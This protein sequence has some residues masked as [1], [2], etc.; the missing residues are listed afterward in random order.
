MNSRLRFKIIGVLTLFVLGAAL[1]GCKVAPNTQVG[2]S[3]PQL[4][5]P[6]TLSDPTWI[7]LDQAIHQDIGGREDVLAYLIYNISID[8]VQ[9]SDD[10]SLAL[11]WISLVDKTTG[12]VQSGEPGLVIGHKAA[13]G[14]WSVVLQADP[15]FAA[16]LQAVPESLLSAEL[17]TE[18]MPA[19]QQSSKDGT[20]YTGY[21]LPW[22][23][24]QAKY[25]TGSIGHVFTYKSCP[26][27]CLYA[28]DFADGTQFPIAAAK[29]GVVKYAVWQYE[30][31]N[32][33]NAN[34]LVIED[35]TTTPTTYMVY[36]HLA[37][38][39]IDTRLRTP[40]AKVYQG[41]FLANADD[42]GLSTGNHL[43]FMVHANPDS[44][45]GTS[46]DV[47]FDEVSV[48][49]GRPRTCA[50]A[51]AYPEYGSQCM[52]SNLYTSRNMDD[53]NPSG[54]LTLPAANTVISA[55]NLTVSGWM[56][57]DVGVK[58]GQLYYKTGS[59]WVALGD[60]I[61]DQ[62]FTASVNLCS[63]SLPMGK[64]SLGLQVTDQ[65]G[66]TSSLDNSAVALDFE[67]DCSTQ[68]PDCTPGEGQATLYSA[69]NF[70]GNCQVLD[71]GDYN[72][73]DSLANVHNGE[74]RSVLP[75]SGV[76]VLL[77]DQTDF[78]G[79]EELLQNGD[80]DLSDNLVG[81]NARSVKVVD[82]LT[83]PAAPMLS[84]PGSATTEDS[85]TL[86]WSQQDGVETRASLSGPSD[87]AQTLDWQ[88]GGSWE[89]GMLAAGEYTLTIEARNIAGNTRI[90]QSFTVSEPKPLPALTLDALP[91]TTTS[92]LIPL[93]WTVTSGADNL[94][95]F[96]IQVSTDGGDW[97]DWT[98]Q[99]AGE[100]RSAGYSGELGHSYA[101][102]VRGVTPTGKTGE[103]A[104]STTATVVSAG[105]QEDE[106]EGTTPGDDD[107]SG[108]APLEIG[109]AQQHNWCPAGDV[110][111]VAFQATAGQNLRLTTS[112][113]DSGTGAIE[114]LYD[115]DG[116]TLLGSASPADDASEA[117]MDWTVPADG[118]YYVRYT[119]VNGQIAG[120]TTYYQ[121][122][123]QAQSSLPTSPLV[124]GG[125]VIP[126]AAGGA[127]LVSSKL[128]NRKKT[129]KRP[130]W[131]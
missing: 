122:L 96:E 95:H 61:T 76:S 64:F 68:P 69:A 131:K 70:A 14:S 53:L 4:P 81:A 86:S 57:D 49:G 78:G 109:T 59:S 2:T 13:D 18:Y 84:L 113:V 62:R 102:R 100:D 7:A 110:D 41:Q 60:P 16:E 36:F 34:Y 27:T 56:Q 38:N 101:F 24:G 20:V 42:T 121:A 99:P 130:G 90:S 123:V 44:Y 10:G 51:Q 129:A 79:T 80:G 107:I 66:H 91:E 104:Q 39:S 43:H 15:T 33:S 127:Y 35:D 111:W 3:A 29:A 5:Q 25:L 32:T 83:P 105:C 82:F 21:R 54:G 112:P 128:L 120:S 94:D 52:P 89:V 118:V 63:A 116:V 75:G 37:Q 58:S 47:V 8:S 11:V 45:W 97:A 73:L 106:Y 108:A 92:T 6:K 74:V 9:F 1:S 72:D 126:L 71:K 46:V 30:N 55:P 119:P 67:Y 98:T 50:E 114:M 103:Y 88:N 26:S 40:G 22:T 125:I 28:F 117:S 85:L 19:V 17:K 124:C 31:G 115:S 12:L 77:Y 23:N 93:S 87:F 48:N 65:A